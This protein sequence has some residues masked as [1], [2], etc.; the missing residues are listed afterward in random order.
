M[1]WGEYEI[2]NTTVPGPVV[3]RL[4][5]SAL[6]HI[7]TN[8]ASSHVV[9]QIRRKLTP[10]GG[11]ASEVTT[12]AVKAYRADPRHEE[13]IAA[14]EEAFRQ[15]KLAAIRDGSLVVR[16]ARAPSKDPVETAMRAI[17]KLEVTAVLKAHG[18]KFP[19]KDETVSD[20]ENEFDGDTLVDRRLSHPE[21][22]PRI[23]KAAERKVAEDN[24]IR[25]N[26]AKA[27]TGAEGKL[28]GLL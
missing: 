3:D 4:L 2:D 19:G 13:E 26:A 22:G 5:N 9:G 28:G 12:D 11:K 17:A 18:L 8:E 24:R 6:A 23:R 27:A 15:A 14:W 21:H 16:I 20:G 1:K 25:E 10:Q 7:M